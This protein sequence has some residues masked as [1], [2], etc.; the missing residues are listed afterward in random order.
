MQEQ[1][2]KDLKAAL[3]AG[4]K[5]KTETLRGLK[6]AILNE[7]IAA[8][9]K[10]SGLNDEQIQKVLA[11]E[12]KRRQEAADL[13]KQGGNLE[14]AELE[15]AEK[16]IIE[17]YLPK[18]LNESEVAKVVD[19]EL[20]KLDKP[21]PSDMGRVIAAVRNRLGATADGATIAGLVKQ[22]LQQ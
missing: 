19:E 3:L 6:S 20:S 22:R 15:L 18:Q 1:I 7:A 5:A 11:K 16:S 13:Y 10:D 4:D 14:R 2:D 17:N 21:Q 12:A 9:V 8:G